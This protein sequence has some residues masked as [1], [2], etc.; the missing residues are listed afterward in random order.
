MESFIAMR[1]LA[2]NGY[3]VKPHTAS[4]FCTAGIDPR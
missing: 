4:G 2:E 1:R 3:V